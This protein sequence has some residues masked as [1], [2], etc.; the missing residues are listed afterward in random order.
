M[1]R[2]AAINTQ[3]THSTKTSHKQHTNSILSNST[4]TKKVV[5]RSSLTMQ[6]LNKSRWHKVAGAEFTSIHAHMSGLF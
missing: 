1:E 4:P 6:E 5:Q 2:Q 3:H